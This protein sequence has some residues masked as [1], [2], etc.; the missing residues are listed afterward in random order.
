VTY[1]SD[2][3]RDNLEEECK[4]KEDKGNIVFWHLSM[5]DNMCTIWYIKGGLIDSYKNVEYVQHFFNS[6][7]TRGHLASF[8]I[9]V[10]LIRSNQGCSL[11]NKVGP[12]L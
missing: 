1:G 11:K 7:A 3:D 12:V 5:L 4:S 2:R 6:A 10:Y 9:T 8:D